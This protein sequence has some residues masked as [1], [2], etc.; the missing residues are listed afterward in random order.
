MCTHVSDIAV[1]VSSVKPGL[2]A[3]V[4]ERDEAQLQGRALSTG[5][6]SHGRALGCGL[7]LALAA[8][9]RLLEILTSSPRLKPGDSLDWRTTSGTESSQDVFRSIDIAL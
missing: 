3:V 2:T 4:E 1:R 6:H 9:R 8:W 5:Q 7:S